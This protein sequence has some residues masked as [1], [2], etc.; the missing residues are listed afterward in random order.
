M[1][2]ECTP[3]FSSSAR[4]SDAWP[5]PCGAPT[6]PQRFG[7]PRVTSCDRSGA[8]HACCARRAAP[9]A[10]SRVRRLVGFAL[11]RMRGRRGRALRHAVRSLPNSAAV[12]P[13]FD[14]IRRRPQPWFSIATERD[15][16]RLRVRR[17]ER[18]QDSRLDRSRI[19]GA[20]EAG[21]EQDRGADGETGTLPIA[22]GG[23]TTARRSSRPI[24]RSSAELGRGGMG[25]V[26]VASIVS[27]G[28]RWRSRCSPREHT[29]RR[30]CAASSRRRG[31]PGRSITQ[32]PRRARHR[33]GRASRTSSRAARS[34]TLGE[35]LREG[36]LPL[37][38]ATS[39][40]LQ[41][42]QGLCAA[43]EK[44]V[45][46][47]ELKPENL[48]ITKEGPAEDSTSASPSWS[49]CAARQERDTASPRPG[50]ETGAILGTVG[51]MSP[52][53]CAGS[54]RHRSDLFS[55][56]A[57]LYEMLA[58]RTAFE[59]DTPVETG[60]RI[61]NDEPGAAG[62]RSG[63]V[64]AH[65]MALSGEEAAGPFPVRVGLAGESCCSFAPLVRGLETVLRL[66]LPDS[67]IRCAQLHRSVCRQ[68]PRLVV[69]MA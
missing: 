18:A 4:P 59:R 10:R 3:F 54:S 45:I 20:G 39:L 47:R 36:P 62:T 26:F 52:S 37:E 57:I 68:L 7:A 25:R 38:G 8:V 53:R 35:R 11:R 49:P 14:L 40:A 34:E 65:R 67:A 31:R 64:G 32:H 55:C 58:G 22:R 44:G 5:G 23:P 42:A 9:C 33:T 63:G 27:S 43:H 16:I 15:A 17:E 61:L 24:T 60:L 28:A 13:S 12:L 46:H 30:R 50:T 6:R 69:R 51:Y 29:A 1:T 66:L 48:F 2:F 41:L 56:G 21:G 19:A